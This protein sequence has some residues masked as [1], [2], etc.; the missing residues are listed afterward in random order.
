MLQALLRSTLAHVLTGIVAMSAWAIFANR[1]YALSASLIA[2][3]TQGALSGLLT[4]FLKRSVDVLRTVFSG[5]VRYWAP[6]LLAFLGSSALSIL[7]HTLANTPEIIRTI[8]VPFAVTGI[9][10]F[11]YNFTL[12]L[13]R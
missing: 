4:L 2:G 1:G 10:I 13:E 11:T 3:L 6:P 12:N 5:S 9:Y 7:G 8:S